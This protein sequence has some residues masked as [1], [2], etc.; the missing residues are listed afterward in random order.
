VPGLRRLALSIL[1]RD[2]HAHMN[3]DSAGQGP[4]FEYAYQAALKRTV[5]EFEDLRSS[6][7]PEL[8][9]LFTDLGR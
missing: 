8:L 2:S 6:L 4:L 7:P 5:S 3:L 1:P 9:A